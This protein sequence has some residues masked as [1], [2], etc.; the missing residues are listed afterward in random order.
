MVVSYETTIVCLPRPVD[1]YLVVIARVIAHPTVACY[2]QPSRY[3]KRQTPR[4]HPV[5]SVCPRWRPAGTASQARA[6]LSSKANVLHR[7]LCAERAH[8]GLATPLS[9]DA[10]TSAPRHRRQKRPGQQPPPR[11][12]PA[13]AAQAPGTKRSMEKH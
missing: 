1:A 5:C 3:K 7:G 2:N 4:K 6:A 10:N 13:P 11:Q 8:K 12:P 9:P